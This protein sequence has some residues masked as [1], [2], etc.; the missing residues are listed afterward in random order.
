MNVTHVALLA[1]STACAAA[2]TYQADTHATLMVGGVGVVA[3]LTTLKA[4]LTDAP[5]PAS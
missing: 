3:V 1:V 4:I 5:K 2:A